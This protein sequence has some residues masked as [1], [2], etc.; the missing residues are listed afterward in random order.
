[1]E[2]LNIYYPHSSS[3]VSEPY[4]LSEFH[5][6]VIPQILKDVEGEYSPIEASA[7]EVDRL[8]TILSESKYWDDD[9]ELLNGKYIEWR[10]IYIPPTLASAD[11][12]DERNPSSNIYLIVPKEFKKTIYK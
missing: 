11:D 12:M 8:N 5:K 7:I 6:W 10:E 2:E 9:K 1:M 3:L 4:G